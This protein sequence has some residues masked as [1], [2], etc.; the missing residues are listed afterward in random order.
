MTIT[1]A[2]PNTVDQ[3]DGGG[4]DPSAAWSNLNNIKE[5]GNAYATAQVGEASGH[6]TF[7]FV[8]SDFTDLSA[9]PAG[10][11]VDALEVEC[12]LKIDA[13]Q[14]VNATAFLARDVALFGD[15]FEGES[16][17]AITRG[18]N[19]GLTTTDQ[20]VSFKVYPTLGARLPTV[21]EMQATSFGLLISFGTYGVDALFSL[22]RIRLKAI[23]SPSCDPADIADAVWTRAERTLS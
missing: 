22:D 21:D 3:W 17:A 7:Q 11:K 14:E 2:T 20:T 9:I 15:E 5:S 4:I 1:I 8:L 12:E 19:L 16:G 23:T 18:A 6:R 13:A 10:H